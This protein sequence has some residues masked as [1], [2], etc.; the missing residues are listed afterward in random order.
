MYPRYYY[1]AASS[2]KSWY[3]EDWWV[4]WSLAATCW[5]RGVHF[6]NAAVVPRWRE[7]KNISASRTKGDVERHFTI[8]ELVKAR[9]DA[10]ADCDEIWDVPE[11]FAE[12]VLRRDRDLL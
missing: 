8:I 4:P 6:V 12:A 11:S 7:A 10:G 1:V 2:P 9:T 5:Q 3:L